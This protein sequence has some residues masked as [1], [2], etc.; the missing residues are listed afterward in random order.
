MGCTQSKI[1]TYDNITI[2]NNIY[3]KNKQNFICIK[4][5]RS[6]IFEY[7][8]SVILKGKGTF[9]ANID[10]KKPCN[11]YYEIKIIKRRYDTRVGWIRDGK[12][13]TEWVY[14]MFNT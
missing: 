6:N 9:I 7:N 13:S 14:N 10:I 2:N 5:D 12:K 4:D 8:D 1:E 11:V 3:Y